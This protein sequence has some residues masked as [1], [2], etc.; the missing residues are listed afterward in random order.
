[1]FTFFFSYTTDGSGG[2]GI[3]IMAKKDDR[4]KVTS[5]EEH[6]KYF[7]SS[8]S[9]QRF[10]C[11]ECGSHLWN[12][13]PDYPEFIYPYASA[14]DTDLPDP[15]QCVHIFVK[16]KP[17]WV[18]VQKASEENDLLYDK[19]PKPEDSI[20]IESWHKRHGLWKEDK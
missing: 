3:N 10:F 14:I 15:P 19:Y 11:G 4:F 8:S 13:H 20:S 2:F 9:S 16:S 1:M 17:G 12:F 18:H 5:G 6:L 7:Q